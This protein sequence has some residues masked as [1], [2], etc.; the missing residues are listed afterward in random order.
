MKS[1]A[2][3]DKRDYYEVLGVKRE[4]SADELKKAYR[5]IAFKTHPDRN[6]GD[7]E[8][9]RQ[10]KEAA[11]AYEVLSDEQKKARY[12]RFG[13]AGLSG[14]GGGGPQFSSFESIFEAFGDIF[15]GGGGGGGFGDFFGGGGGG[16]TRGGSRGASL[17]VQL[18]VSFIEAAQGTDRTIEIRREEEC[19]DC[20]GSGA[21]EGSKPTACVMCGG[22][23]QVQQTQGF[24]SLRTTCPRCRGEGRI[25]GDPCD[26]C[27]GAGTKAARREITIRIPAGVEDGTRMRLS[28]EGDAGTRGGGRGDL[29]VFISVLPHEFFERQGDHLVCEVPITFAQAALG[30]TIEVPTLEGRQNLEIPRGTQTGRVFKLAGRGFKSLRGRGR[31]DEMVRVVLETPRTLSQRH[32]ELL[33]ELAE[34]DKTE[35]SPRRRSFLDK[36]KSFFDADG[37]GK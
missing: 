37:D 6:P 28:G 10:F 27:S 17:K 2:M 26:G 30:A 5:K 25:I 32:E 20:K 29:Y 19:G 18:E 1:K 23:G 13:H 12:D 22:R 21:K 7:D 14:A 24:F 15:G 9:E 36:I 35:V 16:G 11:E 33:R 8:A 4:A 31:G 34:L 3:A